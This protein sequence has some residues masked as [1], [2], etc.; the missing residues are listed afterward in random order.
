MVKMARQR[1]L[2]TSGRDGFPGRL[3]FVRTLALSRRGPDCSFPAGYSRLTAG[4]SFEIDRAAAQSIV[5]G[6]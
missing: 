5:P 1:P 3:F 6:D 2:K 4:N